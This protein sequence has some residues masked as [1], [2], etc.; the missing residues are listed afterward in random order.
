MQLFDNV[1]KRIYLY[2][3]V[4]RGVKLDDQIQTYLFISPF[5]PYGCKCT[6]CIFEEL[7]EN[8]ISITTRKEPK[9]SFIVNRG[10]RSTIH[11]QCIIP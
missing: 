3:G 11:S 8:K 5:V 9:I 2:V 10:K 1:F 4:N 7:K 6:P